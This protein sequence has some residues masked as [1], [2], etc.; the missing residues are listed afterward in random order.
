[1]LVVF[2]SLFLSIITASSS[3]CGIKAGKRI[4][5]KHR[6]HTHTHVHTTTTNF[7]WENQGVNKDIRKPSM[8]P[9]RGR[10]GRFACSNMNVQPA[11][12]VKK[13]QNNTHSGGVMSVSTLGVMMPVV[14]YEA[15]FVFPEVNKMKFIYMS[16]NS[17]F[18]SFD[19]VTYR[20]TSFYFE[21]NTRIFV[22]HVWTMMLDTCPR[23]CLVKTN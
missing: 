12:P 7:Y 19:Y 10:N 8:V 6:Q 17:Q 22:G 23:V 14:L 21:S 4:T 15:K 1:M 3:L 11:R 16:F 20:P 13:E 18:Q 5:C 9:N 2:I